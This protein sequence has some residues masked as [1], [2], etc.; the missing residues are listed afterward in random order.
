MDE[1]R[2]LEDWAENRAVPAAGLP[3]WAYTDPGVWDAEC[4]SVF[5]SNWVFVAFA[6]EMPDPGDVTPVTVGSCPV[7]LVRNADGGISAFHNVCRHRCLKLVDAPANVGKLIRCPY[8]SWA[9]DLNGALR[10]SPHFG[11][12]GTSMRRKGSIRRS[13]G[14]SRSGSTSGTTGSS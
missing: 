6:H 2:T 14:S 3:A 13:T 4:A 8:H 7:L 5:T 10:A 9:Y 1:F 12:T 11:G